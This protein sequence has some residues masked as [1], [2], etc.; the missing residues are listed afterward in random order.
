MARVAFVQG[1]QYLVP[2]ALLPLLA[3]SLGVEEF[4]ALFWF[5][6][7]FSLVNAAS[8]FGLEW[9]GTRSLRDDGGSARTVSSLMRLRTLATGV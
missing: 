4:G 2:L 1:L 9:S 7:A 8:S 5:V 3:R 6:S